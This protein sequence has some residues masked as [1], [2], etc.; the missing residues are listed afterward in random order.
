M[1]S[2]M[3]SSASS[4]F[5]PVSVIKDIHKH[6]ESAAAK[7]AELPRPAPIGISDYT[8]ICIEKEG[9]CSNFETI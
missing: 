5:Y 7:A 6:A 1:K 2:N 3:R 4:L 9:T 8:V